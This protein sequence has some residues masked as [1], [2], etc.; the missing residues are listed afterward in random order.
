MA[1]AITEHLAGLKVAKSHGRELHHLA[2]FRRVVMEIAAHILDAARVHA[3]TRAAYELGAVLALCLFLFCAVRFGGL[4]TPELLLLVFIFARLLPRLAAL[5]ANWQRVIHM[6]PSFAAAHRLREQ[7]IAAEE[8][9]LP[10][11]ASRLA[12][13][14]EIR[15]ESVAFGYDEGIRLSYCTTLDILNEG[16]TRFEQFCREH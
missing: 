15:F 4:G 1:A 12:L 14:R 7:C 8:A 3:T 16:L 9:A 10:A 2:H 6:L 5:Q 11:T 13:E